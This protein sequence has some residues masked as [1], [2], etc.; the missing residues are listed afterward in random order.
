MSML[1]D[2]ETK[3]FENHVD[4]EEYEITHEG[5]YYV[6][7]DVAEVIQREWP[8]FDYSTE[9]R[10]TKFGLVTVVTSAWENGQRPHLPPR[11]ATAEERLNTLEQQYAFCEECLVEMANQVYA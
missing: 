3:G 8:Y 4:L 11:A 7:D 10:D 2:P 1:L 6:P 5:W 9:V